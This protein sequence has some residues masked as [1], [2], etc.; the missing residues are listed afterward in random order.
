MAG[1]AHQSH[2][3]PLRIEIVEVV[4]PVLFIRKLVD[5]ESFLP[6]EVRLR[7]SEVHELYALK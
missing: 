6:L 2:F 3:R 7:G 1:T 4:E 5:I